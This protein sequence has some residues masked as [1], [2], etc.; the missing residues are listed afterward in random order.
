MPK[1]EVYVDTVALLALTDRADQYH[2]RARKVLDMLTR[3]KRALVTLDAVFGEAVTFIRRRMGRD[4][5]IQFGE[6]LRN[7]SLRIAYLDPVTD[8]EAWKLFR[9]WQEPG[10]SY[11]DCT[12]FAYMEAQ[13]LREV[14]TFDNDFRKMDFEV[15]DGR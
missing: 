10:I 11:V 13:K 8:E 5:A 14:F 3:E 15:L 12:S 4:V 2:R 6:K 9:A 1:N 7:G